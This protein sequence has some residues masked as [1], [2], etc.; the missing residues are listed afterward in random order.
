MVRCVWSVARHNFMK[1]CGFEIVGRSDARL[2]ILGSLPGRISLARSEYYAQ[3]RNAFWPIM[4]ELFGA[5]PDL[6]YNDRLRLLKQRGVA[7]WDVCAAGERLG[8]L[9][10]AILPSSVEAN[11]IGEFLRTHVGIS[12]VCF[13]G[14]K[15]KE[16]YDRKVAPKPPAIFGR[17]GF[18]VLPSTSPAHAAMSYEQ[19][20]ARWRMVLSGGGAFRWHRNHTAPMMHVENHSSPDGGPS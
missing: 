18:E 5:S 12:L 20:L 6:P 7:L 14:K 15:A 19:K 17:I 4:G 9:D 10:S 8:S 1:S 11:D 16:I 3:P 2:L 13:N